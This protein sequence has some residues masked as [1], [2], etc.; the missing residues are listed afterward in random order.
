[1]VL[2]DAIALGGRKGALTWFFSTCPY[3]RPTEELG[4][5]TGLSPSKVRSVVR[6][7]REIMARSGA[8][9]EMTKLAKAR[10]KRVKYAYL[11]EPKEHRIPERLLI[12]ETLWRE[13]YGVA[14][15]D[16]QKFHSL[17]QP[18]S[19][20]LIYQ[21]LDNEDLRD[22]SGQLALVLAK[23]CVREGPLEALWLEQN[24]IGREH[25]NAVGREVADNIYAY[26][27]HPKAHQGQ[28][29]PMGWAPPKVPK[30]IADL[31][32]A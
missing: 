26:L 16:E 28:I 15:K 17:W 31:I 5:L 9:Q 3:G 19:M 27:Q 2:E 21:A 6:V 30:Q 4:Q 25:M 10:L 23:N 1:M 32:D 7:L 22:I 20:V 24:S 29:S 11:S 18:L 13:D 12:A 14:L 8:N